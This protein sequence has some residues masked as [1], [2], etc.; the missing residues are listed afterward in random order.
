MKCA[1][2]R[3]STHPIKLFHHLLHMRDGKDESFAK[4]TTQKIK[5]YLS[6]KVS[7][8]S[9]QAFG[10]GCLFLK[11][12]LPDGLDNRVKFFS[13]AERGENVWLISTVFTDIN[14]SIDGVVG[15]QICI[16]KRF[17]TFTPL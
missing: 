9:E 7:Q 4:R 2:E 17:I 6:S 14:Q 1:A 15:A 5:E 11:N 16:N 10:T 12:V 13:W 3:Q 8:P